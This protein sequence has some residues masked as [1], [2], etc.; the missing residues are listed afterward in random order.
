M[1]LLTE[2]AVGF[3][4]AKLY[5]SITCLEG[6]KTRVVA[7][8]TGVSACGNSSSYRESIPLL[9]PAISATFPK[10][11]LQVQGCVSGRLWALK[12]DVF[13]QCTGGC[14]RRVKPAI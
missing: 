1:H 13:W 10:V 2:L 11:Y 9:C 6:S 12:R 8:G 7:V 14:F 5:K 3:G 4:V